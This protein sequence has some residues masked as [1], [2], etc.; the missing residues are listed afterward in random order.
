M[1]RDSKP[2]TN[3]AWGKGAG[4][5]SPGKL[6]PQ[7]AAGTVL[8]FQEACHLPEGDHINREPKG[9]GLGCYGEVGG[10]PSKEGLKIMRLVRSGT[11]ALE[12]SSLSLEAPVSRGGEERDPEALISLP[13]YCNEGSPVG[14]APQPHG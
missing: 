11:G 6:K 3:R 13:R 7:G 9:E 4:L 2:Q 5:F 8:K 14:Q 12:G 10:A 1:G